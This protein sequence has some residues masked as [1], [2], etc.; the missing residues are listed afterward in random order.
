M[1][2]RMNMRL[3]NVYTFAIPIGLKAGIKEGADTG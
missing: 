3:K 1:L 2:N